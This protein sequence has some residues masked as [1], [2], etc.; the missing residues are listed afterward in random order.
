MDFTT[1][2]LDYLYKFGAFPILCIAVYF[3]WGKVNSQDKKIEK[4]NESQKADIRNHADEVK[5]IQQN[6]TNT[7]N[8]LI[9]EIKK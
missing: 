4:L 9:N 2:T 8:E 1:D 5:Q 3:L 6:T 7:L